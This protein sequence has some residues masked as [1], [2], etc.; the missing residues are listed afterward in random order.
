MQR[1]RERESAA[2]RGPVTQR[3]LTANSFHRREAEPASH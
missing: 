2:E 1:T 3:P